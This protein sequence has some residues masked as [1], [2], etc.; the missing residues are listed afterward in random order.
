MNQYKPFNIGDKVI[1]SYFG[2]GCISDY[3]HSHKRLCVSFNDGLKIMC[4]IYNLEKL[5]ETIRMV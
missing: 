2:E 1:H 4:S 5:N 3:N